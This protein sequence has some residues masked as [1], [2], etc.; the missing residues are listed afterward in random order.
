MPYIILDPTSSVRT[1]PNRQTNGQ[2]R[3]VWSVDVEHYERLEAID[4]FTAPSVP[5]YAIT[6]DRQWAQEMH[7]ALNVMNNRNDLN[8]RTR[9]LVNGAP[10]INCTLSAV[11]LGIMHPTMFLRQFTLEVSRFRPRPISASFPGCGDG[12]QLAGVYDANRSLMPNCNCVFCVRA[13]GHRVDENQIAQNLYEAARQ[14]LQESNYPWQSADN[15]TVFLETD[16][17]A[18]YLQS[19]MPAQAPILDEDTVNAEIM[20][21]YE[22]LERRVREAEDERIREENERAADSRTVRDAQRA[23]AL[24][25]EAELVDDR[26]RDRRTVMPAVSTDY[27]ERPMPAR[28]GDEPTKEERI[29][30]L[31]ALLGKIDALVPTE[32]DRSARPNADNPRE[33]RDLAD[34]PERLRVTGTGEWW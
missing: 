18:G 32:K 22:E 4:A 6:S 10:V 31:R 25:A 5:V 23:E 27:S 11:G 1:L 34:R 8:T 2:Y 16:Y 15:I 13:R 20:Q 9:A 29:A 21:R 3:I 33:A 28:T 12:H 26:P 17:S 19:P 7:D 30:S 24:R 14:R